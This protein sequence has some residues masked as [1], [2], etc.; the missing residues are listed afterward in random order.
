MFLRN[1]W[2][3][4]MINKNRALY[5]FEI[6]L[7][8][9]SGN[10]R[11]SYPNILPPSVITATKIVAENAA[12]LQDICF[13]VVCRRNR[14]NEYSIDSRRLALA[15]LKLLVNW[16]MQTFHSTNLFAMECSG[17]SISDRRYPCPLYS[18]LQSP[19]PVKRVAGRAAISL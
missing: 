17:R 12:E 16:A 10:H 1:S 19:R 15:K 4:K 13:D 8:R 11:G 7:M 5:I 2:G 9:T 14:Q 6:I 18:S 3:N